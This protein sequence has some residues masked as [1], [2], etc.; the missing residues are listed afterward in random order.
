MAK[1][2][3]HQDA[4]AP[5]R[6]RPFTAL[7]F[8]L[9]L[10]LLALVVYREALMPGRVLFTTDDNI[11]SMALRKSMLPQA[12]FAGWD[13]SL[14]A[15][16]PWL[17]NLTWT[18]VWL[19]LLPVNVFVGWIHAL[20]L[21]PAAFFFALFLRRRGVGWL[22]CALGALAGFWCGSNFFLTYAGHIGK[23]ATLLFAALCLWLVERAVQRRSWADAVLAGGAMG[24]MFLEQ[25][26]VGLFFA[27]ALGAYALFACWRDYGF[28]LRPAAIIILPLLVAA[29]L[30]AYRPTV[31][32]YNT[33][34][35]D[36]RTGAT[37]QQTRQELWEYCTQWS[38]PP[39]ETIEWLAPGYMGWRSGEP[40]GPYWGRMGRSAGWE[41]SRQGFMN[42]KLETLYIGAIPLALS[43]ALLYLLFTGRL[44]DR[45]RRCDAIFWSGAVLVTFLLGLGKY[46]P[47]YQLFFALPGMSSIRN[48]VKFIQVTQVALAVLVAFGLDEWMR[49]QGANAR[50]AVVPFLKGLGAAGAV[51]VVWL[52]A[53]SMSV[54]QATQVLAGQGWGGAAALIVQN[55]LWAIGHAAVLLFAAAGLL[56]LAVREPGRGL[57]GA[58]AA[59][60]L[61]AVVAL[62]LLGVSR[63]YVKTV[64]SRGLIDR[65]PVVQFL[66][67]QLGRQRAYLLAQDSFYNQ[68]L[69]ILFPY[70]GI[71]SFNVTQTRFTEDY[72]QFLAAAGSQPALL[73]QA[74]A[75]GQLLGPA[76]YWP[77]L[78]RDPV[79]K[80]RTELAFAYNVMPHGA[81]VDVLPS[82]SSRPGQHVIVRHKAPAPRYQLLAA[83]QGI[84]EEA[85]LERWRKGESR[86]LEEAWLAPEVAAR[87]PAPGDRG[88]AGS[89]TVRE[90]RSGR[91]KLQAAVERPAV[92][93]ASDKYAGYWRARVNG[94]PVELFRCDYL[95]Q[96]VFLQPGLQEVVI[97]YAPPLGSL[98]IQLAGA[99]LCLVALLV[100]LRRPAAV[101]PVS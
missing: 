63:H 86:L 28:Q 70:H 32:A 3:Q 33:F 17:A 40:V 93:R 26:D 72:K 96:G 67:E 25:A 57:V 46:F 23:F 39:E 73:W 37:E 18:N 16:Q 22:G 83:W 43:C 95:F 20:D 56:A 52:M 1:Q 47:L 48:P 15:G 31:E 2:P 87:L 78:Q 99:A 53:L 94:Q 49:H 24:G 91:V 11:G 50:R 74:F 42:F 85:M 7:H 58:R 21:V 19:W 71:A 79:L 89:V 61:I 69:S 4:P 75:V 76:P 36:A 65:N 62:D 66:Q 38:W 12:W 29:G 54:P 14:L 30:I 77:S 55:K 51:L 81:G 59:W 92:L 100:T 8:L 98:W 64:E 90:Y 9:L 45:G 60:A 13:D 80:D 27:L 68:W 6:A 44:G 88:P 34:G 5:V 82:S 101:V 84:P 35:H 10:V 41:K 97:E